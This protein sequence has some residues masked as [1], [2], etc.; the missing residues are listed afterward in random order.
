MEK[1]AWVEVDTFYKAHKSQVLADLERRQKG[2][3]QS[4]K[5][6][7]KATTED[8]ARWEIDEQDLPV[9]FQG[10]TG[11]SLARSVLGEE[12]SR[13]SQLDERLED[14]EFLVREISFLHFNI[15]LNLFL[16]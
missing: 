12:K 16:G 2:L 7:G 9:H 10:V 3:T 4:V 15:A 13:K 8:V 14:F 6:K 5:G 11:V 1:E